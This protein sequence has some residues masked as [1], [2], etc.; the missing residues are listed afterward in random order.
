MVLLQICN[1]H[2]CRRFLNQVV[3]VAR[4]LVFLFLLSLGSA[5]RAVPLARRLLSDSH[6]FK[7][8]PFNQAV[9]VIAANHLTEGDPSTS[10]V[11]RLAGINGGLVLVEYRSR[12]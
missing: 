8:E 7:V 9:V 3:S 12:G 6:T 1:I 4:S 2:E 5:C 10:A 11:D